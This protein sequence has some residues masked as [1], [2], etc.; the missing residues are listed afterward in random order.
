MRRSLRERMEFVGWAF[1]GAPLLML[2]FGGGRYTVADGAIVF[3]FG[4]AIVWLTRRRRARYP[5]HLASVEYVR[6]DDY[7]G[8]DALTA[9]F[10]LAWCDC[11][12]MGDDQPDEAAA[13]REA[14]EHSPHVRDGLH[15]FED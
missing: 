2:A 10:Y 6:P 7:H 4:L 15:A 9:P 14:R 5:E 1:V 13:R 12:W 8:P 11:G 3:V